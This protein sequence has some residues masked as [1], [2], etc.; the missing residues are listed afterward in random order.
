M[1]TKLSEAT[2]QKALAA[3][4]SNQG[5]SV[6]REVKTPVGLI[7]LI[8]H[9]DEPLYSNSERTFRNEKRLIEVKEFNSIKHAIGQIQ[10]YFL[11]HPDATK[12]EIIYFSYNFKHRNL[13]SAYSQISIP[14]LIFTSAHTLISNETLYNLQ[15]HA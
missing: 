3:Y 7:D 14:N 5:Y 4:F 12:L 6:A 1:K 10:S 13:P 8:I 9:K 2:V 15:T 11:F